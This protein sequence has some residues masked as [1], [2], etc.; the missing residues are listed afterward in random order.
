SFF[1][2][3]LDSLDPARRRACS[4]NPRPSKGPFL[5][6]RLLARL[7]RFSA[8]RPWLVI[9]GWL[10]LLAAAGGAFLGLGGNLASGFSIPNTPTQQVTDR[11]AEELEGVGGAVGTVVFQTEDGT[12]FTDAQR[13]A[14]ADALAEA[15]DLD[16]VA[17]V[18]DPFATA[19]QLADQGHQLADG[20]EQLDAGR[21]QLD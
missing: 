5:V 8:G 21:E 19:D 7:G 20:Q 15:G 18:V 1:R 16:H 13:A 14:I 11:L 2:H 4:C 3:V 12:P 17:R 9:V 10:V 6:A